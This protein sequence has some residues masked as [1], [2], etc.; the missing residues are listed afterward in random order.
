MAQ[1]DWTKRKT[2]E[3]WKAQEPRMEKLQNGEPQKMSKP[4]RRSLYPFSQKGENK[5]PKCGGVDSNIS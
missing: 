2:A 4:I 5:S 3:V 1:S